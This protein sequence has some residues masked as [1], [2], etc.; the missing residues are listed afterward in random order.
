MASVLGPVGQEG[1][2]GNMSR[3][4]LLGAATF[5][6]A[7]LAGG[8]AAALVTGRGGTELLPSDSPEGVVQRYLLA[9]RDEDYERAYDYLS[10]DV[11]RDCSY[12]YFLKGASYTEIGERQVTLESVRTT[13]DRAQVK[14]RGTVLEPGGLFGA[15]ESSQDWTFP[16]KLEDGRWRLVGVPYTA[17]PVPCPPY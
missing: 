4:W 15:S 12:D 5:V 13:D 11:Q 17:W 7:L 8:I 6:I 3:M 2:D 1:G 10:S 16:L 14:A 9:L